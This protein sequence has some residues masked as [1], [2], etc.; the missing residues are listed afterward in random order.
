M[1][2]PEP[3]RLNHTKMKNL[4]IL[5]TLTVAA[6]FLSCNTLSVDNS[7]AVN[8]VLGD[9]SYESRFGH[10]PD[11]TTDN[12][13]RIR[14]H[15]QYVEDLL[16]NKDV[17]NLSAELQMKRKHLLNLLHDYRTNGVFPK[18]YDYANQRKPC[19][20]DKDGAICAVG[21]LVEQTS[22]RAV[23]NEINR[24]YK[25]A[26]ILAMN[27][28]TVDNWIAASGLTREECAMIQ[29]AYGSEPAPNYN[30]I[31]P[32]YGISSAIM[33]GVNLSVNTLNG[34]QIG[35]GSENKNVPI[36][37]LITGA[38]QVALGSA[39]FPKE[40]MNFRANTSSTNESQKTLSMVNIGLGTSTVIL[41]AWNLIT[42]REPKEK[43]TTWNIYGL[44]T[45]DN[46]AALT[47]S[48]TRKF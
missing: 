21:Y 6:L 20:I 38:G 8:A 27:S 13:L 12:N 4:R 11:A 16:R 22:G 36:L 9:I 47:L 10:K 26:E 37:G 5:F 1:F 24:N 31:T 41:S 32:V 33:S 19:F 35:K 46:N 39:M 45:R 14:T 34:I 30:H 3:T 7:Q 43:R 17:S 18:N 15:L 42:N 44:P 48:M 25:Y 40:K 2:H 23:A 29:P 28:I